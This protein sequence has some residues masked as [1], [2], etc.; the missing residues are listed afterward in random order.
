MIMNSL[1]A[2][3]GVLGFNLLLVYVKSNIT[4]NSVVKSLVIVLIILSH[5]I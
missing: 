3:S 1:R 5:F 4:H 2:T